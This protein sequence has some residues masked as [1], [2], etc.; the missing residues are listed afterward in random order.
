[1]KHLNSV[2]KPLKTIDFCDE[3]D[4]SVN[5]YCID[6]KEGACSDCILINDK[7]KNHS[8][9]KLN[10]VFLTQKAEIEK[11]LFELSL[12]AKSMQN[13]LDFLD[14]EMMKL[15]EEKEIGLKNIKNYGNQLLCEAEREFV[16]GEIKLTSKNFFNFFYRTK[17]FYL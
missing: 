3:H 1:M 11:N 17:N 9:S 4:L 13:N 10:Q 8:I 5:Y 2:P 16:S 14:S 15:K 7:H 6:C 12:K